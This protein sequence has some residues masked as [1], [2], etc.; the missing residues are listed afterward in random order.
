MKPL[1]KGAGGG[2][3][4][5]GDARMPVESPDSLRSIQ[6]ATVLDLVSEGEIGGLVD[7]FKSIYLDDTPLQN[8]DGTY[9]FTG[10][11]VYNRNGTQSQSFIPGFAASEA[12]VPVNTEVTKAISV[13]RTI[14]NSNNTAARVTLSVPALTFQNLT[15]GDLGGTSVEL[16]IDI[17][18]NGG[19][20]VAQPLRT[21]F[22]SSLL[23]ISSSGAL[24]TVAST[25]FQVAVG[26]DGQNISAPQTCTFELQYRV[27]GAPSWIVSQTYTFRG[28]ATNTGG[29]SSINF[30]GLST[31]Y[32][33]GSKTFEL[34][35]SEAEY[36]FRVVKTTGSVQTVTGQTILGKPIVVLSKGL[37]YG[38]TVAITGGA[39]YA[40]AYTDVISGKTT[41]RYQRDYRIELPAGGPW[42]IRVRRITNDSTQQN[43]QNKTFFDSITEVIDAKLTYP[44]SALVG[45]S[46]DAKQFSNIPTRGYE[47]FGMLVKVPSN[48]NPLTREYTG[49]W[50]GT[51]NVAW[52]DNP[53][54]VFYDMVTNARY[55]LGEFV[56][57]TQVDKWGLYT[58]AQYCD[59]MVEDGFGGIEPRFTCNIYLQ[60]R[61]QAYTVIANL[62]SIFRAIAFWGEGEVR[63]SQD[64]PKDSEQLFTKANVIEGQFNYSGSSGSV[65][66]TVVLVSWND[67]Q[68]GYRQKIE[69]VDDDAAIARYGVIQTE[70]V[71]MGCTSRGQAARVGRWLI[72]S[73][74]N[75]TETITFRTGMDSVFV[76]AGSVI[77]TQDSNRAG[78]RYGGRL[79]SSTINSVVLDAPVDIE[80]ETYTLSVVLPDGSIEDRTVTNAPGTTANLTVTPDF[81]QMPQNYAIWIMASETLVP[82]KWRVISI[83]EVDK[84]Q[85]EITALAYRADK[86]DAIEQDLILEPLPTSIV[87][88][89]QPATPSD[90]NVVESLYLVGLSVVGVTATVS[91]DYV[92]TASSYI[93]TYQRAD[94]NPVSIDNIRTNSLDIKPIVEGEYTFTV[95]AVNNL[96]RRSQGSQIAVTIYGKTTPPV[97]VT[98]FSIIK[99]SGLAV[100][101]W[102]LHSDLDVQVGGNIVIRHSSMAEFA[103]WQDGIILDSFAGNSVSGLLPLITGTYMAKAL[104]SSGNWSPEMISF[105]A[106]EGLVTGF[107]TVATITENPDF[108]GIKDF[109]ATFNGILQLASVETIGSMPGLISTWPKLSSLGGVSVAGS[110][111]FE[112]MMD[113]GIVATRRFETAITAQSFDTQDLI[114]YRGLVSQWGS[115]S[116]EVINDC[117]ATLYIST[118]DDD[119]YGTPTWGEYTPFFVADFT[120]RGARYK[121]DLMSAVNTH[122]IRVSN[123]VVK[124]KE[125]V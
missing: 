11:T 62:A 28:G 101:S 3:S 16:A 47:V 24:G 53:A 114:S 60:T 32:P 36:E 18:N 108:S 106:T 112:E 19:G 4:G 96:G 59:V 39:V 99:S 93:L 72:Y 109:T 9:N 80:A 37:A 31:L 57:E 10:V 117:D 23:A 97:D 78:K 76:S 116:G 89:S 40:P 41:S 15:N 100:A 122:N 29:I 26:W 71:A 49:T 7:G 55:G 73:E 27:V 83:T 8:A 21:I 102:A 45:M 87:N 5:D 66:H 30:F 58:I 90:L 115:V 2:K 110:Y 25:K 94:Q 70:I 107:N 105:V 124:A 13:T 61:E 67:P 51:F 33:S 88:S 98:N 74:Q 52:S 120:C 63:V 118:T 95:Y 43:L 50:D 46:I 64:S 48:Y 82:E 42:D 121:L 104:D 84:T 85:F 86:Y 65:R 54:W 113:L 22:Q 38:G 44:N 69:Y 68:D 123:L 92:A 77:T 81:S 20:F 56:D 91:W 34:T 111:E 17:Q 119:P 75:E 6:Y 12:V 1:I 35:L 103:T 125:P 14:N 79:I